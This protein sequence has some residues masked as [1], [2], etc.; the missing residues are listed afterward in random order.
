MR[1][2][3]I[4]PLH[5]VSAVRRHE[6]KRCPAPERYYRE[7]NKHQPKRPPALMLRGPR[8]LGPLLHIAA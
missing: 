8:F 3:Y 1:A 7:Q 6:N 5:I 4:G 2:A